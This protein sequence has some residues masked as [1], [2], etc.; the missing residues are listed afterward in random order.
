[1]FLRCCL[2]FALFLGFQVA[3]F[4]QTT[5]PPAPFFTTY[6]YTAYTVYD[7]TSPDPP[8]RVRG[9]GGT[10]R[11]NADS[12]Y[13]KRFTLQFSDGPHAFTQTGR[14]ALAG[15]SIRFIFADAKGPDVQ[16]GAFQF[17]PVARRLTLTILGYPAGNQGVYELVAEP[18]PAATPPGPRAKPGKKRRR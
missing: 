5:V 17:D 10:L 1:M 11:L 18:T 4:A 12:S 7:A 14:F 9:V 15:D 2:G 6:A 16:R 3:G 8:T 13:A